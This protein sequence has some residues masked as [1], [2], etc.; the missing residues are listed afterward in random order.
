[1]YPVVLIY[2]R[3]PRRIRQPLKQFYK[4]YCGHKKQSFLALMNIADSEFNKLENSGL[5]ERIFGNFGPKQITR[6][7]GS[8]FKLKLL[9]K[10]GPTNI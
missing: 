1:M 9:K 4:H 8:M 3:S 10:R 2:L 6:P 5:F 7:H